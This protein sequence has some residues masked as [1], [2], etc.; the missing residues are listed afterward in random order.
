M[1]VPYNTNVF[2]Y[3]GASATGD[4][5]FIYDI[6]STEIKIYNFLTSNTAN[7]NLISSASNFFNQELPYDF[8]GKTEYYPI[9]TETNKPPYCEKDKFFIKFSD[10]VDLNKYTFFKNTNY[11]L[12]TENLFLYPTQA[13]IIN[14]NFLQTNFLRPNEDLVVQLLDNKFS[15]RNDN[16]DGKTRYAQ[17]PSIRYADILTL[18]TAFGNNKT[19]DDFN[20]ILG[21]YVP[22]GMINKSPMPYTSRGNQNLLK[23]GN[24]LK[25]NIT[26]PTTGN[27]G[28]ILEYTITL[29]N[30]DFS[31]TINNAPELECYP[32][33]DAGECS[34]RKVILKN[35]TG[36][37][38]VDTRNLSSGES[39]DVKIGW[40]FITTDSKVTVTLA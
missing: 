11:N 13:T 20:I 7:S 36:K 22:V 8:K 21:S 14:V 25:L 10:I 1:S 15:L 38:K 40:K 16:L 29:M 34:H 2:Y 35:G 19:F 17:F 4:W 23:F 24:R 18:N 33:V 9:T 37:F 28:D 27:I 32:V 12:N 26:G 6:S 5:F 39:F 31:D 30:D 3:N